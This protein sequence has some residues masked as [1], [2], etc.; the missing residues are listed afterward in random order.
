MIV[1]LQTMMSVEQE[2]ENVRKDVSTTR[3]AS[4]L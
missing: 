3:D 2:K 4:N 1:Q